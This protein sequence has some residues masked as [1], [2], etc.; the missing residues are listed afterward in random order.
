MR[1]EKLFTSTLHR[2]CCPVA[3]CPDTHYS[4]KQHIVFFILWMFQPQGHQE[5]T[6]NWIWCHL[7]MKMKQKTLK[8]TYCVPDLDQSHDFNLIF[9]EHLEPGKSPGL[10]SIFPEFILHAESALKSWFYDFL[11]SQLKIPRIWRRALTFAI[12][13]PEKLLGDPK[14]SRPISRA[15]T[16]RAKSPWKI[17]R[18]PPGKRYGT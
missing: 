16:R 6:A 15:V 18:P 9:L 2:G 5:L 11:T 1:L 13:E 4:K 12:P 10:D 14:S 17:F 7:Q 3:N 8:V